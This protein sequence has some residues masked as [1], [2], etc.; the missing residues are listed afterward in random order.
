LKLGT[1]E[2]FIFDYLIG[3][4]DKNMLNVHA[5][6]EKWS[7]ELTEVKA[8]LELAEQLRLGETTQEQALQEASGREKNKLFGEI[9]TL[10]K[11]V[12]CSENQAN[13]MAKRLEF[14]G[15]ARGSCALIHSIVNFPDRSVA[16]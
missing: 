2:R 16:R 14:K 8:R 11:H 4:A 3:I 9:A 6:S 5:T 7:N 12:T 15:R 1:Q 13:K 10:Q